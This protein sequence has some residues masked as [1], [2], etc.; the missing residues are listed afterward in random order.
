MKISLEKGMFWSKL[1]SGFEKL[2]CTSPQR[3]RRCTN[4]P[5]VED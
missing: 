4:T 1:G 2:V 5:V 3:I